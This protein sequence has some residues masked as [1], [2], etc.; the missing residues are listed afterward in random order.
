M[1]FIH[2][3]AFFNVWKAQKNIIFMFSRFAYSPRPIIP[4]EGGS[5]RL[6]QTMSH[7]FRWSPN[8]NASVI[9]NFLSQ[10]FYGQLQRAKQVLSLETFDNS[11][12]EYSIWLQFFLT[13]P[14]P[15]LP[16][17]LKRLRTMY[18]HMLQHGSNSIQIQTAVYE[19]D[20]PTSKTLAWSRLSE[21]DPSQDRCPLMAPICICILKGSKLFFPL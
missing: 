20:S 1:N 21:L 12:V 18:I 5:V 2:F 17:R 3:D 7:L 14:G 6:A 10:L 11:S 19:F 13:R 8:C 16:L 4:T 9:S 15:R